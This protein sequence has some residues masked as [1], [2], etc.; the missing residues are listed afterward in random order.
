MNSTD[1][2]NFSLFSPRNLHGK[3]NRNV[4]LTMLLIW[5]VAVF[6]FQFLLRGICEPYS[7]ISQGSLEAASAGQKQEIAH[8]N[9]FVVNS[10]DRKKIVENQTN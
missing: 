2:Y 1:Q 8:C 3:K 5:A 9:T 4:I 6:G 10:H 7:G